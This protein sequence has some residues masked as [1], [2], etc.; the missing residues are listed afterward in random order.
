MCRRTRPMRLPLYST[1]SSRA[2]ISASRSAGP[3]TATK[4]CRLV[5]STTL[6]ETKRSSFT[7]ARTMASA[8]PWAS[9]QSGVRNAADNTWACRR[10]SD[11]SATRARCSSDRLWTAKNA[12]LGIRKASTTAT[13]TANCRLPDQRPPPPP[14]LRPRSLLRDLSMNLPQRAVCAIRDLNPAAIAASWRARRRISTA[15][16]APIRREH[17]P[18]AAS[19]SQC[20]RAFRHCILDGIA[21]ESADCLLAGHALVITTVS[22]IRTMNASRQR[23]SPWA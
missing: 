15:D 14:A 17:K 12:R 4:V 19:G 10:K 7:V 3:S 22:P 13:S 18:D 1:N 5:S 6:I 2:T 21:A 8:L 20:R 11:S 9:S 16:A 23:R